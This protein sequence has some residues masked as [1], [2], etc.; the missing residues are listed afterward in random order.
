MQTENKVAETV[1]VR[2]WI[3]VIGAVLGAFMALLD[4]SITNASLQNIQG[5]LSATL[6]E[7][8]WIS[9]AYLV[10]E[11]VV[12]PMTGWLSQVFGLRRYLVWNAAIFVA[13]SML[14]GLA[15]SLPSMIFFRVIQGF[16]G[17]VLIPL[18]VNV[19]L[20]QLPRSKQPVGMTLFSIAAS[21]APTIGPTVGGWLTVNFSWPLV[22]YINIVPGILLI[23][24][25]SRGLDD[26]PRRLELL[27]N[28]DWWGIAALAAALGSL[29]VVLEEG[30]RKDW[31]GSDLI[32]SLAA[33][34]VAS[35]SLFLFIELRNPKPFINIRLLARRNFLFASLSSL[36]FGFGIYGTVF[37][38]P[39]F[40]AQIAR[41][42]ASQIG[43][44]LIWSGLPQLLVLP[45]MP[46]LVRRF[47]NRILA[48]LG[49]VLF[50]V[51][52]IMNS[53]LTGDWA[54]D[55]FFWSQIVRALGQTLIVTPLNSLAY[56]GLEASEVGSASGIFN[57]V[58]NLGGSVGIGT[59]GAMLATRYRLHFTRLAEDTG[60]YSVA[61]QSYLAGA[62]GHGGMRLA[63][64]G[65]YKVM[66]RE[67][68]V[69][70]YADCF[71]V[72]GALFFIG[73]L[74]VFQMRPVAGS[75]IEVAG[76]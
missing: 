19:I 8:A 38:L 53:T 52:A 56:A 55:Q 47:D 29:T 32:S 58:R 74:L 31:F 21:F 36:V 10:A 23:A 11:I 72:I 7:G 1:S 5:G 34:C 45:F 24:M 37:I 64:A 27:E 48:A 57:M 9:T 35:L 41:L 18:S 60:R 62:N 46:G 66:N 49:M 39:L 70:A 59:L 50:G 4:I 25:V 76:H 68:Y 3:A 2:Q 28:G 69:M 16:S 44:I 6:D 17:G 43:S 14:C 75:K 73:A 61:A 63:I 71:F 51:S 54:H 12:I 20:T 15:W 65:L 26:T 22:F 67:S 40:L 42:D 30:V 33:L 13:A